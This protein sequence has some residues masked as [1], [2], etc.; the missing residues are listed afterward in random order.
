MAGRLNNFQDALERAAY[1]L[2]QADTA[3]PVT[4]PALTLSTAKLE[5]LPADGRNKERTFVL[6]RV[7]ISTGPGVEALYQSGIYRVPLILTAATDIDTTHRREAEDI[8]GWLMDFVQRIDLKE[9]LTQTGLI[10]VHGFLEPE[11]NRNQVGDREWL[12][13]VSLPVVGFATPGPNS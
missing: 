11:P 3:K 6:P 10:F 12:D 7:T 5:G 13:E 8:F 2:L 4:T 9:A 1:T